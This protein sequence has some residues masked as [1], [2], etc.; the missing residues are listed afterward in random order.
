[1]RQSPVIFAAHACDGRGSPVRGGC[2]R[3]R[4]AVRENATRRLRL[5]KIWVQNRPAPIPEMS[6]ELYRA[7][8]DEAH[9]HKMKVVVHAT[10]LA[11]VKDLLRAGIDG[12][13]HLPGEI[14]EEL[15]AMLKDRPDVFL[16]QR[17]GHRAG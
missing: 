16:R 15:M 12:F 7:T 1:M 10:A 3:C 8:I 14:D 4:R 11:D 5:V 9:K 6:P 13:A 2:D 17:S